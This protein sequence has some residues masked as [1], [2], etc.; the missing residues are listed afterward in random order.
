MGKIN[1][2][3][4]VAINFIPT[5]VHTIIGVLVGKLLISDRKPSNKILSL[6][7]FG[8]LGLILGFTLDGLGITPIIK[9][10]ST[11]SFVLASAGWVILM[12]AFLYWLTDIKKANKYAW[13]F[14]V[15]GLNSIFIYLFFETLGV[16]WLNGVVHLF[17]GGFTTIFR[18][19]PF[20]TNVFAA[21][22]TLILEWY[23]CFWLFKRK[24]IFKI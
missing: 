10:I 4:W 2:D 12:M 3:G 16:Q 14:V 21:L 22:F 11:S 18:I 24:I 20:I 5:A 19:S 9:R 23:L 15:V 7:K 13:I 1:E 8:L 6:V 17:I